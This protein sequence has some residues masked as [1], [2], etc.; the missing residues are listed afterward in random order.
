MLLIVMNIFCLV[1][2]HELYYVIVL[3]YI[4]LL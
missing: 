3:M 1:L 2:V 4:V